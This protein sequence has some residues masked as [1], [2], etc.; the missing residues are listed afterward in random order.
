MCLDSGCLDVL[1]AHICCPS[2]QNPNSKT[3]KLKVCSLSASSAA[4]S[5]METQWSPSKRTARAM[6]K[7]QNLWQPP[8]MRMAVT[9]PCVLQRIACTGVR[10]PYAYGPTY[11]YCTRTLVQTWYIIWNSISSLSLC[12][13]EAVPILN[14]AGNTSQPQQ[15]LPQTGGPKSIALR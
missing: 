6:M 14:A 5:N 15:R 11:G 12:G 2:S 3:M 1:S 9:S 13:H 4:Y 7:K 8:S 10:L